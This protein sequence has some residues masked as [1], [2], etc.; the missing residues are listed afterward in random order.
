MAAQ[1]LK[2]PLKYKATP[3]LTETIDSVFWAS[4]G[5]NSSPGVPDSG[6]LRNATI[7]HNPFSMLSLDSQYLLAGLPQSACLLI[8]TG[9]LFSIKEFCQQY[10]LPVPT[11][12][13]REAQAGAAIQAELSVEATAEFPS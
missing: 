7:Q 1:I 12:E 3:N 6:S 2:I 4:K 10:C 8:S 5:G 9:N 13:P 11:S